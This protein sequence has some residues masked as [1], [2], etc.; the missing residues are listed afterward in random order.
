M[1]TKEDMV[2]VVNVLKNLLKDG[3]DWATLTINGLTIQKLPANKSKSAS[4]ALKFNPII[5]GK[6]ARKGKYFHNKDGLTGYYSAMT[7][8]L[9][10]ATA[11]LVLIGKV[12]PKGASLSKAV[13][14]DYTFSL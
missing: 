6:Q 4:L 7:D 14:S 5:N 9:D 11:L 8:S 3:D 10:L 12:N 13:K 1:A 2:K